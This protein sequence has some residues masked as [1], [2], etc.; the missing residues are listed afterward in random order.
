MK[1]DYKFKVKRGFLFKKKIIFK[2]YV[3]FL[4]E[5]K[6][7]SK[8]GSPDYIISKLLMNSLYGRFG[9]STNLENHKIVKND[10]FNKLVL[11]PEI[12]ITDT[13]NLDNGYTLISFFENEKSEKN[14]ELLA[15][16]VNVNIAIAASITAEA[17]IHMSKFKLLNPYKVFYSD[18][19][20]IDLDKPL[21]DELVG[22]ELGQ[23][24]LEHI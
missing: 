24:K 15:S 22:E 19:D 16:K 6:K 17:R 12:D 13:L 7:K 1:R 21:P 14:E 18:T 8:K 20:S 2:K 11:S 4:Y 23:M 10:N 3:D 5:M 9:M